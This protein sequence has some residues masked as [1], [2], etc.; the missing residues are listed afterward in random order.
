[1]CNQ[2]LV[3]AYFASDEYIKSENDKDY[4]NLITFLQN[5][6]KGKSFLECEEVLHL[7]IIEKTERAFLAGYAEGLNSEQNQQYK[8][9][10]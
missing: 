3:N 10:V 4:L 5:N 7:V 6:I 8:T 1:M 2:D 9:V